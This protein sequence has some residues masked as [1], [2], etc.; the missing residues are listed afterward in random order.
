MI[1]K[2]KIALRTKIKVLESCIMPV[3]CY[4]AETWTLTKTQVAKGMERVI[5]GVRKKDRVSNKEIKELTKVVDVGYVLKIKKLKYAGHLIR[6]GKESWAKRATE[7]LPYGNSRGRGRLGTRW[8][9]EIKNR[10]RIAWERE[11]WRREIW[12]KIGETYARNGSLAIS[13]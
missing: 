9:D 4:G 1:F 12:R 6:G 13:C 11:V 10:V 2:S 5:T 8:E 3:L 7:W